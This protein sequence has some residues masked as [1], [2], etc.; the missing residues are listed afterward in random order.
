MDRVGAR[1]EG[2]RQ[3]AEHRLEDRPEQKAERRTFEVVVRREL[4]PG[5]APRRLV[6]KG[7]GGLEAPERPFEV[8]HGDLQARPVEHVP[9]DEAPVD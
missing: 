1:G 3:L 2:L 9:R 5:S 8:V 6:A 7:P 4:D